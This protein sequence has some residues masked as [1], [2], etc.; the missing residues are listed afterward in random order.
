MNS[1]TNVPTKNANRYLQQLC[2]HFAHKVPTEFDATRGSIT[3]PMGV[4][5]LSATDGTLTMR[6]SAGDGDAL[7]RLQ[8]VIASHLERFAFREE[9]KFDWAQDSENQPLP[10]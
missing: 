9:L 5:E 1:E 7:I 3:L 10:A 6:G 8:G 4:C 2:K